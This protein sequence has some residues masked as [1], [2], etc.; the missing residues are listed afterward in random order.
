[1]KKIAFQVLADLC[2]KVTKHKNDSD[3][4]SHTNHGQQYQYLDQY[5]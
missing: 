1:M 5:T 4:K 3:M 2:T